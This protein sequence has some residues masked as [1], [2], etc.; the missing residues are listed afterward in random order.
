[1]KTEPIWRP[2]SIVMSVVAVFLALIA[3]YFSWTAH[4]KT[5]AEEQIRTIVRDEVNELEQVRVARYGEILNLIRRDMDL[6]P[7]H[8]ETYDELMDGFFEFFDTVSG[9]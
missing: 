8:A 9:G 1:M 2:A 3:V 5:F 7:H 6:P 4:S